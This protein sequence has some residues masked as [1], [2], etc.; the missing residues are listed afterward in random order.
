LH[1]AIELA[2]LFVSIV[3][4]VKTYFLFEKEDGIVAVYLTGT[5]RMWMAAVVMVEML[6]E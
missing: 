6:D 1:N 3:C 4:F 5:S 2:I